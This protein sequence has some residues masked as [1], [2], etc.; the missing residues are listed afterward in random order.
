MATATSAVT[1]NAPVAGID[2]QSGVPGI[3]DLVKYLGGTKA[4]TTGGESTNTNA[5]ST[6]QGQTGPLESIIA[7]LS[8]P[9]NLSNLVANLFNQGAAQVPVL[10]SQFANATGTR[11]NNNS[12][13]GQSLAQLNTNIMQQIAGAVVQQQQT[14]AGAAGK[15]A[16][17]NK[18]QTQNQSANTTGTKTTTTE[19][20]SLMKAGGSLAGG[21]LAGTLINK[22]GKKVNIFGDNPA[23]VTAPVNIGTMD[24]SGA[25]V[26][27]SV[28][29]AGLSPS[30]PAFSTVGDATGLAAGGALSVDNTGVGPDMVDS[31]P[32][33]TGADLATDASFIA[34][35]DTVDVGSGLSDFA[36]D[37][38]GLFADG[39]M[40]GGKNNPQLPVRIVPNRPAGYAD[41]GTIVRNVPQMGTSLSAGS[42][43]VVNLLLNALALNQ[44]GQAG[45]TS[46]V[47]TPKKRAAGSP[48]APGDVSGAASTGSLSSN[49][50]GEGVNAPG[51][52]PVGIAAAIA[53]A[54]AGGIPAAALAL[55]KGIAVNQVQQAVNNSGVDATNTAAGLAVSADSDSNAANSAG[56]ASAQAGGFDVGNG[57]GEAIGSADTGSPV[58]DTSGAPA[59]DSGAAASGDAGAAGGDGG[60]SGG[61]DGG[62]N[63]GGEIKAKSK[64]ALKGIDRQPIMTTP[65]E[66]IL[67]IDV[68]NFIGRDH[69]DDLV[70]LTHSR[71]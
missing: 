11:V 58:G 55:G 18:T 28:L 62:Y 51:I 68:V 10:T 71:S 26:P 24:L 34:N 42:T 7:L 29:G 38:S 31:A 67:P 36:S 63:D 54:I 61:G 49:E 60:S 45:A 5:T 46:A 13:L 59:G 66:Y 35:S 70:A 53:A 2:F 43:P 40:V 3:L 39:G 37:F 69:L 65:G 23:A 4:T 44:Q 32:V 33:D 21:V 20:G 22:L 12:M 15:L 52:G 57:T 47:G 16:E 17:V 14:A 25:G 30:S 8:D 1:S 64:A 19:P 41:G 9:N 50:V 48:E 27:E 56:I 6:T